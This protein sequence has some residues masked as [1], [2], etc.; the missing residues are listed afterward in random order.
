MLAVFYNKL[1]WFGSELPEKYLKRG[2][3]VL[4]VFYNKLSWLI[5]E[6]PILSTNIIIKCF[7]Q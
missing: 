1:P 2:A 5:S 4:A 7:V 3:L 6:L